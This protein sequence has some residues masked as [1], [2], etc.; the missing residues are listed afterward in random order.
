[1]M[2]SA[3]EMGI[4]TVAVFSAADRLA[5]HVQ[6]ADEAV[7]IG[8]ATSS[9]SYL[10]IENIINACKTTHADAV[11]PGYG[12]LSENPTFAKALKAAGI[13]LIGPSPKAMEI[14]GNKLSAKEAALHYNIPMIKGTKKP[15]RDLEE[16]KIQAEEIGF[17]ILIKAAAGGGGK[18]MRI[19]N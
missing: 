2:R 3:R 7:Y 19:V 17:P 1:I 16:A 14:M 12:F 13:K 11:H 10:S 15:I 18:G 4:A 8:E 5:L 9:Q 6:Y